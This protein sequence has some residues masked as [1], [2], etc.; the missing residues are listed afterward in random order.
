MWDVIIK[1]KYAPI[2]MRYPRWYFS[3]AVRQLLEELNIPHPEKK[4][5]T[6]NPMSNPVA[7]ISG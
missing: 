4:V 3:D 6:F 1:Y 5:H 7:E 2:S